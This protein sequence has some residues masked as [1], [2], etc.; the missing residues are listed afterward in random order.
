MK[1]LKWNKN[2]LRIRDV[3]ELDFGIHY[4][5][6]LLN[7]YRDGNDKIGMHWDS[8]IEKDS[9]IASITL[10]TSR[11]FD[12]KHKKT[13]EKIRLYPDSGDCIIMEY[14]FQLNYKH[15]VPIQKTISEKRINLTYRRDKKH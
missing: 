14:D 6:L 9:S 11:F 12:I 8:E 10:G 1:K 15:G 5:S 4:D 7:Y 3:L 2:L 13:N